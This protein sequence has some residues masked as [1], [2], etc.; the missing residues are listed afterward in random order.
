MD[1]AQL[2]TE[3]D[4]IDD[5]LVSLFCQRMD[6]AA[7]IAQYKKENGIP[8]YIPVREQEKLEDIANIA[9]DDMAVYCQELYALIFQL[10]RN[11]QEKQL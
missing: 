6:V 10:S 3:I 5:Q 9:G 1:L 7:K 2:R 11:H 4:K 8:V